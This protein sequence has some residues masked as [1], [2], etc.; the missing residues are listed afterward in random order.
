MNDP[1]GTVFHNG[2]YHVFYQW[3]PGSDQW[4]DIHWG[5]ARSRDLV[6][7]E[8][9][10]VAL[11]PAHEL[12]EEHCFSGCLVLRGAEP[13]MIL[14]TAIG[15]RME[16]RSGAQQWAALGDDELIAW[17][18]H[19]RNPILTARVHGDAEVLDWR[20]PFVFEAD[21]RIFML[22]AGELVEKNGG[23]PVV[24]LYEAQDATLER[25][26]YRGVLFRHP[27]LMRQS[28]ECPNFFRSGDDWVLLFSNFKRVEYVIGDFDAARGT[29]TPHT[30]GLLDGSEQFYATNL[31][32]DNRQR[33]I[34]FGWVRG[35]APGRGWS[36]CLSLP[37]V[38]LVD[39]NGGLRQ[40]PAPELER[41]RG[42]GCHVTD[43]SLG[44]YAL[45]D[46]AS[47]AMEIRAVLD[48]EP[49]ATVGL[50][51]IP[52]DPSAQPITLTCTPEEARLNDKTVALPRDGA[53][54]ELRLF[55]D[56][57][58]VEA[59]INERAALTFVL[60]PPASAYRVELFAGGGSATLRRMEAWGMT[61]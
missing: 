44:A 45:P 23:A 31:L 16:A 1:N 48:P 32:L 24:L 28:I 17:R 19:P 35:F 39:Q 2:Y 8:H 13:P 36:G 18:K 54:L 38:L 55:L 51:L 15:P 3:N 60:P 34:G 5:H 33:T 30:S 10:P 47:E 29:F 59:F 25:W 41:L 14:Y 58:V 56:R 53:A 43:L 42:R 7:W 49:R 52:N 20:D 46:F 37:R 26:A 4:G 50:R 6:A 12:G 11:E 9:L 22:L 21:G 61:A 40:A 27:T 57:S